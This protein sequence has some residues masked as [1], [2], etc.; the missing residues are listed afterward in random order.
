[1]SAVDPHFKATTVEFGMR[2]QTWDSLPQA[3]FSK[4]RLRGYTSV[5]QMG[6]PVLHC[7]AEVMHIDFLLLLLLLLLVVVVVVVVVVLLLLLLLF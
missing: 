5:G 2:V 3:K 7:S 6:L 1:M 4:S